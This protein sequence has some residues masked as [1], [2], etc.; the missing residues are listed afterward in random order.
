MSLTEPQP[1]SPLGSKHGAA[2][3]RALTKCVHFWLI[4]EHV[5]H[6]LSGVDCEANVGQHAKS[7]GVGACTSSTEVRNMKTVAQGSRSVMTIPCS[8]ATAVF[9]VAT[10]QQEQL[11][12]RQLSASRAPTT[13]ACWQDTRPQRTDAGGTG[14][15]E[16]IAEALSGVAHTVVVLHGTQ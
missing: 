3:V 1:C 13:W 8:K 12:A 5:A 16:G 14:E 2:A 4:E 9:Q 7:E 15:V 10:S 6:G 11:S